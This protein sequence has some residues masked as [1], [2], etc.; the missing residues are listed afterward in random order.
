MSTGTV[1]FGSPLPGPCSFG[2]ATCAV[3]SPVAAAEAFAWSVGPETWRIALALG[4]AAGTVAFVR[5]PWKAAF[6][7]AGLLAALLVPNPDL[8]A[9]PVIAAVWAGTTVLALK[10]A[11]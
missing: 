8:G 11:T 10:P 9:L 7:G 4:L 2:R 6:W 5:S 3:L 1:G